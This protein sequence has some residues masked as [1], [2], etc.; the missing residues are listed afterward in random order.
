MLVTVVVGAAIVYRAAAY[1]KIVPGVRMIPFAADH[2][3]HTAT[4]SNR[5]DVH[6]PWL[7]ALAQTSPC[8]HLPLPIPALGFIPPCFVPT[9]LHPTL[10]SCR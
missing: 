5:P 4:F 10:L 8:S 1:M 3:I 9:L 2:T 6:Q 7:L